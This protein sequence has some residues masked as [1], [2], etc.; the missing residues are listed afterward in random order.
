[1]D[2]IIGFYTFHVGFKAANPNQPYSVWGNHTYT[3]CFESL[4]DA[5]AYIKE[6]TASLE[7]Y[8]AEEGFESHS[9]AYA[10]ITYISPIPDDGE[11]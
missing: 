4:G 9:S 8:I 10:D 11:W 3:H 5:I 7:T 1:M 6:Q 2:I